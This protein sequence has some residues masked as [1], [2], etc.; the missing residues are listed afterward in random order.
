MKS[1]ILD[2]WQGPEYASEFI[3]R[4]LIYYLLQISKKD[5]SQILDMFDKVSPVI[6]LDVKMFFISLQSFLCD[7]KKYCPKIKHFFM[8]QFT[9]YKFQMFDNSCKITY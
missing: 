3:R 5:L 9:S 8:Y 2:A 6:G 4:K 7:S 1:A